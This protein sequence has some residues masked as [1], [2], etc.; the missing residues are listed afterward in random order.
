LGAAVQQSADPRETPAISGPFVAYCVHSKARIG[1]NMAYATLSHWTTT[2]WSDALEEVARTKFIPQI[3]NIGA[4]GVQ[5]I[6][7]GDYSFT[8]VTQY[9]DEDAAM[10][11]MSR[12]AALRREAAEELLMSMDGA[13]AGEV[14]AAG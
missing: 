3:M 10:V 7:T 11:A 13:S 2:E 9:K 12:I 14:F 5:M 6:R 8:V 1:N 4:E